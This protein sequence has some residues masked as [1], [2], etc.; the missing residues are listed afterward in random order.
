MRAVRNPQQQLDSARREVERL[1]SLPAEEAAVYIR[2]VVDQLMPLWQ[3][4]C[5]E[6]SL[7]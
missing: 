1:L 6:K 4:V 7:S 3:R 5:V 2:D